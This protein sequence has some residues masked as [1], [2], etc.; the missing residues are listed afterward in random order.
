MFLN[1][2]KAPHDP[3]AV[4]PFLAWTPTSRTLAIGEPTYRAGNTLD[5]A[6]TNVSET[7]AWVGTEECITS[8]HLPICGFVPNHKSS[9]KHLPTLNE[10]FKV[11]KSNIP[12]F[13]RVVSQ[14]LPPLTTLNTVEQTEN[15]AQSIYWAL[16]SALKA[17]DYQDAI[18]ESERTSRA[19]KFI[20]T[21]A[22][23]KR[24]YWKKKA[25]DMKTTQETF[26]L[27]RWASPRQA[28]ITPPLRH[29]GR[30]VSDQAERARILRD[31]LLARFSAS[32][33]L[34]NC[35]LSGEMEP[36]TRFCSGCAKMRPIEDFSKNKKDALRKTC[37]RHTKKRTI[38]LSDQW[39]DFIDK[40]DIRSRPDFGACEL[41]QGFYD[42]DQLV[43]LEDE[44]PTI[45]DWQGAKEKIQRLLD[46]IDN[47]YAHG[48]M[49]FVAKSLEDIAGIIKLHDEIKELESSRTMLHTWTPR[50][51]SSP[52]YYEP[53]EPKSK[54]QP[55]RL[56]HKIE[57]ASAAK[58]R[59]ARK[60]KKKCPEWQSKLKK[61]PGIPNLFP[62]KNR[63][64][65]EIEET[66]RKKL[67]EAERK[68][69]EAKLA[70]K[71][72]KAGDEAEAGPDVELKDIDGEV[73]QDDANNDEV[74]EEI[75][76][77]TNPM[78]A[79]L[80][81]ARA[82]AKNFENNSESGDN[83]DQDDISSDGYGEDNDD[84]S[85]NLHLQTEGSR[86]A[87]DKVFKQVVEQ[88]D[89]ILYVLDA[90]D[91]EGTRSKEVERMIM[92]AASGEK[93]LMLI[94]N[95]IDLIPATVLRAW[96]IYLRRSFPTIPLR[97]S[98]AAPNAHT[99]DHKQLTIKGTST[100]LFKALKLISSSENLKR[101]MTVGVIGYPNVGK[102]S[103]INALTTR[104][105][106]SGA[107]CPVGAEAGVTT[108][109][110]Q[111]KLDSKLKLLDSPGIV[112]PNTENE[113]QSLSKQEEQARLILLNAI[114]PK[115]IEDPVP[116][117]TLLLKR[118]KSNNLFIKILEV[119][120]LPPLMPNNGDYTM[121]FLV[122][123]ARKRGRLGKGG[124]PNIHSAGMMVLTDWRDGRIQGWIDPPNLM[125][126]TG[127]GQ[128]DLVVTKDEP[129]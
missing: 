25:E 112:F 122:Q 80:A 69:T 105:G 82:A 4:Q 97:A 2:Y 113:S 121:D 101:F 49:K 98:T 59:K 58:Q 123:V 117:V 44:V 6:F 79:L 106:G 43:S 93:H 24:E 129:K 23:A 120:D 85:S 70:K 115:M 54:R 46:K 14:W 56:R 13:I 21:V 41:P 126:P 83:M 40:I 119:Y 35:L 57:K 30:F 84:V 60:E 96:L 42:E 114:P 86:R 91:P 47:Q 99:F 18:N 90:R 74:M 9:N 28:S 10:K 36:P 5:L 11:T 100:T 76:E 72:S 127:I 88:A 27:M 64:L 124:I 118:L 20:I 45:P 37:N 19:K 55:V 94:L 67:E 3:V 62:Y 15:Y 65:A 87:F 111:V 22:S 102:S 81:S 12:Q 51:F 73:K 61:D 63:I 34:P 104:L 68:K 78:A 32:D 53:Y 77:E 1:V 103:V 89:I 38:Q 26:K 92:A 107:A 95:K 16:D 110:R 7:M 71:A 109:L 31:S 108:S 52:R 33:D 17:V 75:D 39:D 29:Q 8:D 48:N 66:R 128:S 50:K 125:N 116:A